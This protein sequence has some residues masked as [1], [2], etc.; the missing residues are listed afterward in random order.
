MLRLRQKPPRGEPE[1]AGREAGEAL[2]WASL[3]RRTLRRIMQWLIKAWPPGGSDTHVQA[4]A[5]PA[6]TGPLIRA[7]NFQAARELSAC[8]P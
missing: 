5:F 8:F 7:S 2:V 6:G 1:P 4:L 3:A